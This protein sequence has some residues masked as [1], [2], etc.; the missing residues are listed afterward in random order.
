VRRRTRRWPRA[1]R[2]VG[3]RSLVLRHPPP[4]LQSLGNEAW[5]KFASDPFAAKWTGLYLAVVPDLRWVKVG[6]AATAKPG[7][8][9]LE[10][11]LVGRVRAATTTADR[12]T[13]ACAAWAIMPFT[14][15]ARWSDS[16]RV[17]HAVAGKLAV[18]IDAVSVEDKLDWLIY[19][20]TAASIDWRGR[21]ADAVRETFEFFELEQAP[22]SPFSLDV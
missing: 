13:D 11:A 15:R 1:R 5:D 21:F 3:R 16:Q 17:E 10:R 22:R 14:D 19:R 12:T 7:G 18:D 6:K 4:R 2:W 20:P 9:P 8:A